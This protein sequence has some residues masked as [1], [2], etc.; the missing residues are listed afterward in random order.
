MKSDITKRHYIECAC[1]SEDHLLVFDFYI[2]FEKDGCDE[3]DVTVSFVNPQ[4]NSFKQR[5]K[6]AFRYIFKK[7]NYLNTSDCIILN[8]KNVAALK[9]AVNEIEQ[10]T[11]DNKL[12]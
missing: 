4:C 5:V 9:A 12:W 10:L 7:D 3:V 6:Y 8:Q 1:K 11:K 2:P